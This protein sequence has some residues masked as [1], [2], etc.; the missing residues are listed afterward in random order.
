V[1]IDD[2]DIGRHAWVDVFGEFINEGLR[3]PI[4]PY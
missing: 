3:E 4:L 2:V 1:L